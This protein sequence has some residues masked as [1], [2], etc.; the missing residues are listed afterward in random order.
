MRLSL[1]WVLCHLFLRT[2]LM[3]ICGNTNLLALKFQ[4]LLILQEISCRLIFRKS[5][6]MLKVWDIAQRAVESPL[7][8]CSSHGF[9]WG[10]CCRHMA[11]S[12]SSEVWTYRKNWGLRLYNMVLKSGYGWSCVI[13]SLATE[14]NRFMIDLTRVRALSIMKSFHFISLR[15]LLFFLS[16]LWHIHSI[17][18]SNKEKLYYHD[19]PLNIF[20]LRTYWKGS[21]DK[22]LV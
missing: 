21:R 20:Y 15:F 17:L 7:W 18:A 2:H 13:K 1:S 22:F 4:H 16:A 11:R 14:V 6:P 12:C 9:E 3:S 8:A 19:H 5:F 10:L